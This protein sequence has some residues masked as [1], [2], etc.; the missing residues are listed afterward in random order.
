MNNSVQ[1]IQ[2]NGKVFDKEDLDKLFYSNELKDSW[3]NVMYDFLLNWFDETNFILAHTSG[4]TGKPKEIKLT[5]TAMR[6]S[7]EMTNQFFGLNS[8]STALLCL[9]ATY[10][11]GKMMLVRA[12]VGGFNLICVEPKA[13]PFEEI[14]IEIDFAAITPYQLFHSVGSLQTKHIQKIIVGGSPVTGKLE[15]LSKDLSSELYETYGM[16]ETCSHIA[17]RQ[18]NGKNKQDCFTV[19]KDISIRLDE[20]NC[21]AISVSHLLENEI[22]TNDFVEIIDK[23]SFRWLGRIDTTINTGGVKVH[24]EQIEK[25]LEGIILTNFFISSVPDEILENKVILILETNLYTE[26]I[27]QNLKME[28][29][30]I[31]SK[32]EIPKAVYSTE[33]FVYTAGNK[34]LRKE[35]L[36][37]ILFN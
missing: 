20:R 22:T 2:I 16:T 29:E 5:K 8:T 37:K 4:S 19:L 12:I 14:N 13:N 10:I 17:L 1:T 36:D 28:F 7:A 23:N 26:L 24:P 9:P 34:I 18:F 11:A 33:N 3:H 27:E 21:L 15:Q 25:K 31:L 6:N 30:R 35:T 32:F